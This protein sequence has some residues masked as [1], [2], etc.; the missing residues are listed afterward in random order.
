MSADRPG[1]PSGQP[2]RRLP[3][4]TAL[5][6]A[7]ALFPQA[8]LAE[9]CD[10]VRPLWNPAEGPASALRFRSSWGGLAAVCGW[11]ALVFVIVFGD[12]QDPTGITPLARAEGCIGS[13]ALFIALVAAICVGTVVYTAPGRGGK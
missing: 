6:L 2:L 11:S 1:L 5:C 13:P 8:A 4:A 3:R 9:V 7:V 12:A 10:K